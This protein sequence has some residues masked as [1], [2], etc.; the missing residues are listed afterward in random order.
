[1][2][3][4]AIGFAS[5]LVR[6]VSFIWTDYIAIFSTS[7]WQFSCVLDFYPLKSAY[8]ILIHIEITPLYIHYIKQNRITKILMIPIIIIFYY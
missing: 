1:M 5:L 7:F 3:L 2:N 6:L 8:F 4:V